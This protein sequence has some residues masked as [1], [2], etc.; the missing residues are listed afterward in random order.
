MPHKKHVTVTAYCE[1]HMRHTN[2]LCG[3]NVDI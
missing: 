1:N 2:V 3:Q